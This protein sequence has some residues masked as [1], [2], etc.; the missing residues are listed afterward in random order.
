MKITAAGLAIGIGIALASGQV[1][2]RLLYDVQPRDPF[3][4][5]AVTLFLAAVALA[6]AAL[7]AYRATRIAPTVAIRGD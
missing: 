3:V 4:L 2:A 6:A 1:I 5:G 7:P